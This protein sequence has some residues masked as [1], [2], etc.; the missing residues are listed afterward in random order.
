MLARVFSQG[1]KWISHKSKLDRVQPR[2]VFA[3]SFA[4]FIASLMLVLGDVVFP[5]EYGGKGNI[6]TCNTGGWL[7]QMVPVAA[8]YNAALSLYYVLTVS[9][10]K[11]EQSMKKFEKWAHATIFFFWIATGIA[12]VILGLFN[13]AL[14]D[15]WIFDEPAFCSEIPGLECNRPYYGVSYVAAQYY[16]YY[17]WIYAAFVICA[18]AM[19]MVY[20]TVYNQEKKMTK[21]GKSTTASSQQ[22]RSEVGEK[23]IEASSSS[24]IGPLT[25]SS[26]EAKDTTNTK[27]QFKR[28]RRVASQGIFYVG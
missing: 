4:D 18:V 9:Y 1:N 13:P 28:S 15:C 24:T 2:L 5:P 8:M 16:L 11:N 12:G 17:I 14:F 3:M 23:G 26:V 10:Q 25:R 22:G 19:F 20:K 6:A 27:D 21:Y 7:I